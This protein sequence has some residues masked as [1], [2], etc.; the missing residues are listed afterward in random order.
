MLTPFNTQSP[1]A[2]AIY[3]C[4][5][6]FD[7]VHFNK[8]QLCREI[9]ASFVSHL[10][11]AFYSIMFSRP[12]LRN[13]RAYGTI[14]VCPSSVCHGCIMAK[15]CEVGSR[16]LVISYRKSH[17]PFQMRWK[18]TLD[19]LEGHCQPVRSA[20]SDKLQSSGFLF[21]LR[22]SALTLLL[23]L[24][25]RGKQAYCVHTAYKLKKNSH[26]GYYL[27]SEL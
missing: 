6:D 14:V 27:Q 24:H 25:F 23:P 13:G 21:L 5:P 19:N 16:L 11:R 26:I 4:A 18:S 15:R 7:Q 8:S 17:T 20:L 9:D 3:C 1:R 10:S 2:C 12:Y 22:L